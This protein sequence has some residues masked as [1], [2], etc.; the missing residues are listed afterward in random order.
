MMQRVA[1]IPGGAKGIGAAI[2]RDLVAAGW[3]VAFCYRHSAATAAALEDELSGVVGARVLALQADVSDHEACRELVAR[4][5]SEWGRIDALIQCAGPYHR[6]PL[7]EE[8]LDGWHE[9]FDHNL[10]PVFYLGRLVAPGM[11]ERGFGRIV[12]FGM[13]RADRMVAQPFITGHYIA[14]AAVLIL[15]RTLAKLLAPHG[16]TVNSVSPGYIDSG[17]DTADALAAALPTIPAG[18]LGSVQDVVTAV[19][20]LLSDEARYVNGANLEVGGA[21]GV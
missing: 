15:T 20:F 10:H 17:S 7:F 16:I 12:T 9:M 2:A 21:W 18:Y 14:K 4:V 3:A 13:A 1:L 19:R 8:S 11:Q 5:Q 6:V